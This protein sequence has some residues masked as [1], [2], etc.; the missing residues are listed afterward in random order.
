[1]CLSVNKALEN[2]RET[3]HE[4]LGARPEAAKENTQ[5]N[6]RSSDDDVRE[7]NEHVFISDKLALSTQ[8]TRQFFK[9]CVAGGR[10]LQSTTFY[11]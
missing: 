5:I 8:Y 3:I 1:M 7:T 6:S 4:F 2:C 11:K 10:K 9:S